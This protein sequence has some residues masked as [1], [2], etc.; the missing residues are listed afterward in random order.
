MHFRDLHM[1]LSEY[2][3]WTDNVE[4]V[5]YDYNLKSKTIKGYL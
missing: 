2:L 4:R 5:E 1:L 3:N